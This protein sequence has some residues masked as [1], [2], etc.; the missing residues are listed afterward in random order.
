MRK[1]Y[2]TKLAYALQ[3]TR[4]MLLKGWESTPAEKAERVMLHADQLPLVE[5][6]SWNPELAEL[7]RKIIPYL[8]PSELEW[9]LLQAA[10]KVLEKKDNR[11]GLFRLIFDRFKENT[12]ERIPVPNSPSEFAQFPGESPTAYLHRLESAAAKFSPPPPVVP[13]KESPPPSLPIASLPF[14]GE[15]TAAYIHRLTAEV[16]KLT[17]PPPGAVMIAGGGVN[18]LP[19]HRPA[20]Q[21]PDPPAPPPPSVEITR[22]RIMTPT[23]SRTPAKKTP[24]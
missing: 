4:E 23:P 18:F 19:S 22:N 11:A 2:D 5:E 13:I 20:Q 8:A 10:L 15:S 9:L 17:P 14:P 6:H 7:W 12:G 24:Q 1:D 16:A 3:T 21:P